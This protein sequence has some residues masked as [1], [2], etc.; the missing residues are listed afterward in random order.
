MVCRP[1][2]PPFPPRCITLV[3]LHYISPLLP[4]ASPY[5]GPIRPHPS[6][7]VNERYHMAK[8]K[9]RQKGGGGRGHLAPAV[10]LKAGQHVVQEVPV[11][12]DEVPG[13]APHPY[14]KE[15]GAKERKRHRVPAA[16]HVAAQERCCG[17]SCARVPCVV[18]RLATHVGTRKGRFAVPNNSARQHLILSP[19]LWFCASSWSV[20]MECAHS[21]P[22]Q[23]MPIRL[24]SLLV[25]HGWEPML[26]T[27]ASAS[28]AHDIS[29][30]TPGAGSQPWPPMLADAS[31]SG[32]GAGSGAA[33]KT[34]PVHTCGVKHVNELWADEAQASG[35]LRTRLEK[36]GLVA[37][38]SAAERRPGQ[39]S[40]SAPDSS[41]QATLSSHSSVMVT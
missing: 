14:R 3:P 13:G 26:I 34:A 38:K 19:P 30:C 11:F 2:P 1:P 22:H 27:P 36:G 31:L 39:P 40:A 35:R 7:C 21:A 12:L 4:T 15:G 37:R 29:S 20:R 6:E 16:S 10:V 8:E 33:R 41:C 24:A 32:A 5:R 25:V 18:K 17:N 23:T 9:K 28:G